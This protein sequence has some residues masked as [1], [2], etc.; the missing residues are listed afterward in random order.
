MNRFL[1]A[2]KKQIIPLYG[3]V[4][5]HF[6]GLSTPFGSVSFKYFITWD[7][8]N[9]AEKVKDFASYVFYTFD[10]IALMS[11]WTQQQQLYFKK[12]RR[13][14][15]EMKKKQTNWV[16]EEKRG[17]VL[18][19]PRE[20]NLINRNGDGLTFL[21]KIRKKK[22]ENWWESVRCT[23]SALA[24]Y[25]LL[26][27]TPMWMGFRHNDCCIQHRRHHLAVAEDIWIHYC[28]I[29]VGNV[30]HGGACC[31]CCIKGTAK[32]VKPYEWFLISSN[33]KCAL[34]VA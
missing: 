18:S 24:V 15:K 6:S 3:R 22:K 34:T 1:Y 28:R 21:P 33:I 11:M 31:I 13:K 25:T 14:I 29:N 12:K 27:L 16:W 19:L 32:E 17:I 30:K 20:Q 26:R 10:A 5:F 8:V 7:N 9:A 2:K 4:Y 23:H